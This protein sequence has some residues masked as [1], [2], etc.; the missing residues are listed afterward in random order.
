MKL[1]YGQTRISRRN[2]HNEASYVIG[3]MKQLVFLFLFIYGIERILETFWKREKIEGII[4]ASYTLPLLVGAYVLFYLVLLLEW[5]I[6][7]PSQS[8]SWLTF[9]G[10]TMVL[11]SIGGRNWAIRTLGVYHS[12]HIEIRNDH[13]LIRSGPYKFIRNPYYLSNMIEA[14]GLPLTVNA[15]FAISISSFVYIPLLI[16]RM[17]L[18]ERALGEKLKSTFAFY[19][20]EAPLILPKI[21]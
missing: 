1:G 19:K 8:S 9:A 18:E 21:F 11:V 15:W 14:I 10:M 13:E 12:I 17:I 20:K 16:L 3:S 5:A 2:T 4:L 6:W 7:E